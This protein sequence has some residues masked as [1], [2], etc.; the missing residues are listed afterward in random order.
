MTT[1]FTFPP[2]PPPPPKA[3]L[4]PGY[5]DSLYSHNNHR[6]GRAGGRGPRSRGRGFHQQGNA[7]RGGYGMQGQYA[8]NNAGNSQFPGG[9]GYNMPW[10]MTGALPQHPNFSGIPASHGAHMFSQQPYYQQNAQTP[11]FQSSPALYNQ[12]PFPSAQSFLPQSNQGFN[13]AL[14]AANGHYHA[15]TANGYA[16]QSWTTPV[17][18]ISTNSQNMG[19]P[20][21]IGFNQNVPS[22]SISYQELPQYTNFST[23]AKSYGSMHPPSGYKRKREGNQ[24][25]R[26]TFQNRVHFSAFYVLYMLLEPDLQCPRKTF[27]MATTNPRKS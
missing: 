22:T 25:S 19:P 1:S 12:S 17:Q 14:F 20:L 26:D 18:Q 15:S 10:S 5:A 21:R 11:P 2:P 24:N 8:P 4:D 27:R 16:S 6:G 3:T 9:P 7:G 23:P 13:Q